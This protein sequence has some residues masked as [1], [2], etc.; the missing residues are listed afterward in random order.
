VNEVTTEEEED[1]SSYHE[2]DA[3]DEEE[4]VETGGVYGELTP[5]IRQQ[6]QL[7][8]QQKLE[9]QKQ[10]QQSPSQNLAS[11]SGV[12]EDQEVSFSWFEQLRLWDIPEE[13][14]FRIGETLE[15]QGFEE[16]D[17]SRLTREELGYLPTA[18]KGAHIARILDGVRQY[19]VSKEIN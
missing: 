17:I 12:A 15:A 4:V 8:E 16:Q 18:I 9:E 13:D 7:L 11:N 3:D 19:T 2:A 6:Q 1:D 14:A 10:F 5:S